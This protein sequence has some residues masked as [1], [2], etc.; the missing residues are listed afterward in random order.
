MASLDPNLPAAVSPSLVPPRP[1]FLLEMKIVFRGS[2]SVWSGI[3]ECD[4]A[5]RYLNC[6]YIPEMLRFDCRSTR[7]HVHSFVGLFDSV[8]SSYFDHSI[9][10]KVLSISTI[11]AEGLFFSLRSKHRPVKLSRIFCASHLPQHYPSFCQVFTT[12]PQ[13]KIYRHHPNTSESNAGG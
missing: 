10:L 3:G 7:E 9:H 6:S 11:R 4:C 13:I 12:P 2:V 5:P 1:W 8:S